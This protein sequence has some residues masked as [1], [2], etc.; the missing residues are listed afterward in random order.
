M[1]VDAASDKQQSDG[2]RPTHKKFL[3]TQKRVWRDASSMFWHDN[4]AH[5]K[6]PFFL[7]GGLVHP[8]VI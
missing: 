6:T 7:F 3:Q 1:Y 4:T 8:M 5:Q 2:L